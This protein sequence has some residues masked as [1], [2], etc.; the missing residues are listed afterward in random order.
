MGSFLELETKVIFLP[1]E[2]FI[3]SVLAAKVINTAH[4]ILKIF[5]MSSS[6]NFKVLGLTL[7][8]CIPLELMFVEGEIGIWFH[9]TAHGSSFPSSVY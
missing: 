5:P 8:S 1:Q 9:L 2:A 3:H 7:R 4:N 6:S